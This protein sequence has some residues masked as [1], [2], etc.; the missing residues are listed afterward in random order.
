MTNIKIF[1][2]NKARLPQRILD[3]AQSLGIPKETAQAVWGR[4]NSAVFAKSVENAMNK[5]EDKL[6]PVTQNIP[7]YC[8]PNNEVR[9]EKYETTQ[10][11]DIKEIAKLIR[12]DIKAAQKSGE[13]P[14]GLKTSVRIDRYAGGQSLDIRVTDLGGIP[15]YSEIGAKNIK[16]TGSVAGEDHRTPY[17]ETIAPEAKKILETLKTIQGS[18]NRDNSDVMTDYF[19]V[20]FY[21]RV[22]VDYD[23]EREIQAKIKEGA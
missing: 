15:L 4:I 21:G 19:D 12:A 14:T 8:D 17:H 7:A 11:L 18:Y 5:Q 10:R 16:E 22:E 6:P 1:P 23:L 2:I 3:N 13:L 9:G 20:R